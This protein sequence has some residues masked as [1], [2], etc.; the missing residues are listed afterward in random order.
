MGRVPYFH[1]SPLMLTAGQALLAAGTILNKVKSVAASL[2]V[3][4]AVNPALESGDVFYAILPDGQVE[5]HM[6]ESFAVPLTPAGSQQIT[7]RTSRPEG[8]VPA[9]E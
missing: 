8:D 6:A 1:T 9:S 7:T 2:N 4:A 5:R 3:E